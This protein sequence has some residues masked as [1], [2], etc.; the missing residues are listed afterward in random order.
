M[1]ASPPAR[2]MSATVA[3]PTPA[4]ARPSHYSLAVPQGAQRALARG[5]L[6]LAMIALVGS[7]LFSVLL[8]VSRT[9]GLNQWLPVADFFRVALVVHVDLS[10]LVW[11]IAMAGLLWSLVG[12][13]A[14]G[15]VSRLAGWAAPAPVHP[16]D[17]CAGT[18]G[19]GFPGPPNT[20]CEL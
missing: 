19:V 8:V 16:C 4:P 6:W 3:G 20:P 1:N 17:H 5:W 14:A 13:P 10:V 2:A 12:T 18:T 9:P 11:F 7:G 15:R